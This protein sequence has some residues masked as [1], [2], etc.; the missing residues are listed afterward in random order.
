MKKVVFGNLVSKTDLDERLIMA[1]EYAMLMF[2]V[3][4]Y[5]N[6]FRVSQAIRFYVVYCMT[7]VKFQYDFDIHIAVVGPI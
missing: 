5:C 7:Q 2:S 3:V 6:S 4:N 1:Q